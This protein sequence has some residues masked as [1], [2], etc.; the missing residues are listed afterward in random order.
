M[1]GKKS[2]LARAE[3]YKRAENRWAEGE[4]QV[5][6]GFKGFFRKLFRRKKW[7]DLIGKWYARNLKADVKA[8]ASYITSGQAEIDYRDRR[9]LA[10]VQRKAAHQRQLEYLARQREKIQ[11]EA[12]NAD[13]EKRSLDSGS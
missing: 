4:K 3:A 2:R 7:L 9:R 5:F 6:S 11:K 13:Q 1:N 8:I 10:H 12:Q